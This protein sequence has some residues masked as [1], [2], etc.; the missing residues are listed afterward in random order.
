MWGTDSGVKET[1]KEETQSSLNG[2]HS[3]YVNVKEPYIF[4][5][6][7]TVVL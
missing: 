7:H 3:G 1:V 6:V 4:T 5:F 2:L